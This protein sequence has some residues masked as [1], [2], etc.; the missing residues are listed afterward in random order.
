MSNCAINNGIN[1]EDGVAGVLGDE[2][3]GVEDG[4]GTG[5]ARTGNEAKGSGVVS[6]VMDGGGVDC[7]DLGGD[8]HFCSDCDCL[9]GDNSPGESCGSTSILFK[10]RK[11]CLSLL[12]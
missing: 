1:N 10:V 6:G 2:L 5:K 3:V 4:K 8:D 11:Y 12:L 9:G 7:D